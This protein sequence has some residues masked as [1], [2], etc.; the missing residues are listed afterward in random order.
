MRL[1]ESP[2]YRDENLAF[3]NIY[4][5]PL[6]E[7]LPEHI[8]SLVEDIRKDC[9]SSGLSLDQIKQDTGLNELWRGERSETD[10]KEYLK[11]NFFPFPSQQDVLRRSNDIPM[12]QH[13]V[14]SI[15]SDYKVSNPIPDTL[16]GYKSYITFLQQQ[17]ELSSLGHERN[18]NSEALLF[19]FLIIEYKTDNTGS[20][21][22]A[23]NQCLGASAS[24]INTTERLNQQLR[25]CESSELPLVNSAVFSIATN[26]SEVRLHIS[27][28]YDELKYY[29]AHVS[30]FVLQDPEQYL[31][32]YKYVQNIMNWGRTKRLEQIRESLG[33][34][35]K[36]KTL[37][38]RASEVSDDSA[39][40]GDHKRKVSRKT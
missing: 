36:G 24:C 28:K 11:M 35:G 31:K 33:K 16:F 25:Q 30:S 40:S 19:P 32:F 38:R 39:S 29:M 34:L 2:H 12:Y 14:P 3:N 21:K 27:W 22:V 10:I 9:D 17:K 7:P 37:K 5:R 8:A 18:A 4:L 26:G 20:L 23:T 1:V 13:T 6:Y 15:R